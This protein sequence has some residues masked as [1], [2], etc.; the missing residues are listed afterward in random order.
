MSLQEIAIGYLWYWGYW[1][2]S[3]NL[4]VAV[5]REGLTGVPGALL[6]APHFGEGG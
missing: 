3:V 2:W 1:V 5:P 6:E 4:T